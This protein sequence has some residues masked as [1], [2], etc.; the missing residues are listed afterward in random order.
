MFVT[1][2]I[3]DGS[4]I[5]ISVYINSEFS[6]R[7]HHSFIVFKR[8]NYLGKMSKADKI[9]LLFDRPQESIAL[10]K[11]Q[12]KKTR[13]VVPTNYLVSTITTSNLKL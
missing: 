13:F 6:F 9:L 12:D 5:F 1:I 10:G 8:I 2:K 11:G 3:N 4:H 7:I